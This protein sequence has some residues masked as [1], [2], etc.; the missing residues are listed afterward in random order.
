MIR[1]DTTDQDAVFLRL[2]SLVPLK[3]SSFTP[4]FGSCPLTSDPFLQVVP[5]YYG[6]THIVRST[7]R[8]F[9]NHFPTGADT[10]L[11]QLL[12]P[13]VRKLLYSMNTSPHRLTPVSIA[14][15]PALWQTV[16]RGPLAPLTLCPRVCL[17][18]FAVPPGSTSTVLFRELKT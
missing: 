16:M 14:K 11:L 18:M 12:V 13:V 9:E 6:F 3:P 4:A 1:P 15:S 2:L 8:C 5:Y 10:A 7:L 17:T